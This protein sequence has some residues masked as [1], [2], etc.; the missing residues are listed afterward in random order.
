MK[1]TNRHIESYSCFSNKGI[2]TT[3]QPAF[4]N[5]VGDRHKSEVKYQS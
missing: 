4:I 2:A 5:W 3:M 1:L